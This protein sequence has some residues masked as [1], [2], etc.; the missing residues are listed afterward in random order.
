[1]TRSG[2]GGDHEVWAS[3]VEA[4]IIAKIASVDDVVRVFIIFLFGWDTVRRVF[5][6]LVK[7]RP[8]S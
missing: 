5:S 6:A 1:M 8:I 4:S 3:S 7:T 2:F